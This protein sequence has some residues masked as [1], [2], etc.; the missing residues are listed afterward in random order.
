MHKLRK[1]FHLALIISAVWYADAGQFVVKKKKGPSHSVLAEQCCQEVGD[2][3][4][5]FPSLLKRCAKIQKLDMKYL[6]QVLNG[7]KDTVLT[8][9]NKEK[10]QNMLEQLRTFK[11]YLHEVERKMTQHLSFLQSLDGDT[12][13][14]S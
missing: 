2:I 14:K 10:L 13:T 9:V 6:C 11:E 7:E 12:T 8:R 4:R 1:Y 5:C 3:L